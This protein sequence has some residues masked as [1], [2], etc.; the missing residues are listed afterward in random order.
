VTSRPGRAARRTG[1]SRDRA[2]QRLRRRLVAMMLVV[3]TLLV[4]VFGRVVMLQT[5]RADEY[6]QASMNQRLTTERLRAGRGTIFDRHGV[7]L[8]LSVPSTTVFADPRLVQDPRGT[9]QTLGQLL[10]WNAERIDDM[11]RRLGSASSHFAY[12]ER[13][14]SDDL[15]QAVMALSLPGIATYGEPQRVVTGGDLA[16]SILGRTDP[17]GVGISGVELLHDLDLTG[18]DG[19]VQRELDGRGRS[20]PTGR[21]TVVAPRPGDD[22]VLTLDRSIQF[23][24][25]QALLRRVD[26]LG[27][28]RG[29]A[30]VM[31]SRTGAL[32]AVGG[33]E[34][35]PGQSARV[36]AANFNAVSAHEPGS[37]AKVITTAAALN[38]DRVRPDTV[39]EVPGVIMVDDFKITDAF[40]HG[41]EPM[42]VS[43]ILTR[44]SNIGTI[45]ISEELGVRRQY[46]YLRAFGFGERTHLQLPG[47]SAGILKS[48]DQWRGTER[49]TT[50]YG[51]GFAATSLQLTAAV[52]VIANGGTYVAPRLV[53]GV[54]NANGVL[55][56]LPPAPTRDVLRPE[57]AGT[58]TTMMTDVVCRGTAK[59]AQI[60]GVS[61]AGKT[62]T[63][64]KVQDNGT[65]VDNFGR[66]SYFASFVGFLPAQN[67]QVTILVSIDEPDPSTR[68]R[69]GG[70][71]AAP[72][73]AEIAQVVLHELQIEPPVTDRGCEVAS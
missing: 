35:R 17:D 28:R 23:Q 22:L 43:Q 46:E 70:T 58:M 2:D 30:I 34:R 72:V 69:F 52:N 37:V 24:V 9:A 71:A 4:V 65:Y 48:Y 29:T 67:P 57:V 42:T 45:M 5:V 63:G 1:R 27:A 49:F 19:T 32:L 33:V 7:E 40:P 44:S 31:D 66:R 55:E 36:A 13:Q 59:L 10:G 53:H 51:Y 41:T 68:D 8:A 25:E 3:I 14:V 73:F 18:S 50:S 61:V 12:I 6:R 26:Q 56:A 47:E 39:F 60:P 15:A 20:L 62:G 64:Y 11:T 38:D 21:R 16:R 54:V